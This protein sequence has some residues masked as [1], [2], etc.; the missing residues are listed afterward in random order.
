M[1]I[2]SE[3]SSLLGNEISNKMKLVL[4][5]S[6]SAKHKNAIFERKAYLFTKLV[7]Q[8]QST[9]DFSLHFFYLLVP[10]DLCLLGCIFHMIE[11]Q[12]CPRVGK[13]VKDWKKVI[14]QY[15]G[16][17]EE[18]YHA[19]ITHLMCKTQ[20]LAIAQQALREGKRLV[21]CYWLNDIILKKKV[22]PP[23]KAVHFPL[24]P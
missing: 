6:T 5:Q 7:H 14:T 3:Y 15:G 4:L 16:E 12:D 22:C 13:H 8:F 24:P 20:D 2:K 18:T 23:W 21:T 19:R 10:P 17:V 11:Y 9:S 1:H